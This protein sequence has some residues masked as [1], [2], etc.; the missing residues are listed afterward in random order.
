MQIYPQVKSQVTLINS[1]VYMTRSAVHKAWSYSLEK[2]PGFDSR[3]Q[4]Y[5]TES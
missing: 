5:W 4:K 3:S 2:L 1:D